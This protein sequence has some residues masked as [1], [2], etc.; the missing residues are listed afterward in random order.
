M[1]KVLLATNNKYKLAE[2]KAILGD[3]FDVVSLFDMGITHEPIED[4]G[5]FFANAK[6]K[7][8][9]IAA[10]S[11]IATIADDSGLCVNAL[12][13]EPGVE[14]AYFA[15]HPCNDT[16][17]NQ[18]LI[19]EMAGKADRGAYYHCKIVMCAPNGTVLATGEG[20]VHGEILQTPRGESG[21]G[22]DP[23]FY[24]PQ[25]NKTMAQITP[26][27]KNQISHRAKAL[28]DFVAKLA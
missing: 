14:S 23:Y 7:A 22:Y 18:K 2:I 6:I 16:A 4:G 1:K 8:S 20:Q 28:A 26:Q 10:L 12:G 3:K 19:K 21:F 15:G 27:E 17:N 13:G 25:L 11:G 5:S 24:I 9:E